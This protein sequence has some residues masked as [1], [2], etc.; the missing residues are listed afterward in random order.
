MLYY[1]GYAVGQRTCQAHKEDIGTEDPRTLVGLAK[2]YFRTVGWGMMDV[3]KMSLEAGEAQV[4]V[5][6]SFECE[7]GKGSETPYGHFIRG[8]LAG[9][10]TEIFGEEAKAV[11][12]KC[13]ATGDP[14]CEYMIKRVRP[15]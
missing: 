7:T 13:I 14:Y 1:Q 4:R 11:E 8:I 12:T 6:Q 9:F 3:V 15:A 2:A 5:Y 10:F